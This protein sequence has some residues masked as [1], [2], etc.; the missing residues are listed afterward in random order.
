LSYITQ[1]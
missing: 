1:S